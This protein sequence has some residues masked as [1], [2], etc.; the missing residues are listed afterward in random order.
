MTSDAEWIMSVDLSAP[1]WP[2]LAA[3]PPG[4]VTGLLRDGDPEQDRLSGCQAIR[5]DVASRLLE[6]GC[7]DN[8]ELTRYSL[9]CRAGYAPRTWLPVG[10]LPPALVM[11]YV[12]ARL[13]IPS[14]EWPHAGGDQYAAPPR[15]SPRARGV[16]RDTPLTIITTCKGRRHHLEQTLPGWLAEPDVRVIAVDYDCPDETG[17]WLAAHYPAV[18]V[19]SVRHRPI[20]NLGDARNFGARVAPDGWWAF[21][22]ADMGIAQGWAGAVRSALSRGRYHHAEP[23][24]SKTFGSCVVHSAD[25]VAAGGYDDL[26]EGWGSE[27]FDF[28]ARCRQ[29]NVRPASWGATEAQPIQHSDHE[30]TRFHQHNKFVAA[31]LNGQYV[32]AKHTLMTDAWRLPTSEECRVIRATLTSRR[33]ASV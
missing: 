19:V 8:P 23:L 6:S 27:D 20:F 24:N 7:L 26:I 15:P 12:C 29:C 13:N 22:D 28:Y 5:R 32:W 10:Y 16:A 11:R 25:Y 9:L 2:G 18:R 31:D 14:A 21:L 4:P 3:A 17:A 30:R 33:P 1:S